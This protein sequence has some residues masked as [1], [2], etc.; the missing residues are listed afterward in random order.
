MKLCFIEKRDHLDLYLLPC[1]A[2]WVGLGPDC[3]LG[4]CPSKEPP[5]G[6]P[7]IIRTIDQRERQPAIYKKKKGLPLKFKSPSPFVVPSNL[8]FRRQKKRSAINFIS[9]LL[10]KSQISRC[11]QATIHEIQRLTLALW[12]LLLFEVKSSRI[13]LSCFLAEP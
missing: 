5:S 13:Y 11:R 6:P 3:A 9:W 2:W 7:L 8:P 10:A 4:I 1:S 12:N